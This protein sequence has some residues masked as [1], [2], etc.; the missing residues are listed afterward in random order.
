M[1]IAEERVVFVD[2]HGT[3][4]EGRIAVGTPYR[5]EGGEMR[6]PISLEGFDPPGQDIAGESSLQALLLAIRFA[7]RRIH[8][9]REGGGRIVYP[10]DV[11]GTDIDVD[12]AIESYFGPL[13]R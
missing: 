11:D 2:A 6:C 9:F 3:R 12:F 10:T 8:S 5:A 4:T 7:G 1:W 13:I